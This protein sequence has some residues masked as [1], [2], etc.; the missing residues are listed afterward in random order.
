MTKKALRLIIIMIS[1]LLTFLVIS[2][3]IQAIVIPKVKHETAKAIMDYYCENNSSASGIISQMSDEDISTVEEII[4]NSFSTS[5]FISLSKYAANNDVDKIKEY[6]NSNI[7]DADKQKLINLY[8][9]YKNS[10]PD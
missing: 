8:E 7:S 9:K 3:I 2:L 5:D 1:I 10:T 4:D 6:A